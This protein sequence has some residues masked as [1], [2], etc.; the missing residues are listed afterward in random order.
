MRDAPKITITIER[1][2]F[3]VEDTDAT[4]E[5][6]Q[7]CGDAVYFQAKKWL[8]RASYTIEGMP[9]ERTESVFFTQLCLS[10]S[11]IVRDLLPIE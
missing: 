8:C 6:C 7:V 3:S 2:R 9:T 5:P 11:E 1:P 4:G 10:C